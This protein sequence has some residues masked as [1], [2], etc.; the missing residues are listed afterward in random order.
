[1]LVTSTLDSPV[2]HTHSKTCNPTDTTPPTD[3]TTA[4]TTN[5]VNAP[6]PLTEYQKDTL[7]LMQK[8]D[9]FCKCIS[10]RLLTG[11]APSHEVDTFMH[12]KNLIYKYLMDSN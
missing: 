11:K 3:P 4:S 8:M 10:K 7:R 5:K 12:I 9:P 6:S 2:T 1:M